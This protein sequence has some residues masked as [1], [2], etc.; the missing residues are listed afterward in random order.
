M[1]SDNKI[2]TFLIIVI[3]ITIF[4]VLAAAFMLLKSN[5]DPSKS[6]GDSST[7]EQSGDKQVINLKAKGGYTPRNILAKANTPSVLKISTSS[8]YD[9][10][11]DIRISSLN[12]SKL[13]PATGLT[14]VE[15][16]A[17]SA[18]AQIKGTCSMGMYSFVINFN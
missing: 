15:I 3:S 17:Q 18:G 11:S 10:S 4:A 12:F 14:E 2:K 1:N 16:P 13:L 5:S 7:V 8:T 9:C 6:P